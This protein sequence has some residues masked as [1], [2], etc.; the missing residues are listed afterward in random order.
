MLLEQNFSYD[1]CYPY[2]F[3]RSSKFLE[4]LPVIEEELVTGHFPIWFLKQKDP[5]FSASFN[6]IVIRDPIERVLS[7]YR[8]HL[9]CQENKKRKGDFN[10]KFL[11]KSPLEIE[12]N[13]ISKMLSSNPN[14]E[15]E[16]LFQ[17]CL[18]NL[19]FIDHIIFQ[20]DPDTF[21]SGIKTLFKRLNIQNASISIPKLNTTVHSD[22]SASML[23]KLKELNWV[24]LQLYDFIKKNHKENCS[25][26]RQCYAARDQLLQPK[27]SITYSFDLPVLGSGWAERRGVHNSMYGNG[28]ARRTR[29]EGSLSYRLIKG[30]SADMHFNLTRGQSYILEFKLKSYKKNLTPFLLVNNTHLK[31]KKTKNHSFAS[32]R[33]IIPKELI[34]NNLTKITFGSDVKEADINLQD[35]ILA[36]NLITIKKRSS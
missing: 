30:K 29:K 19:K 26:Y 3:G 16:E 13:V 14:L 31:I 25:R 11:K 17:S 21:N 36:L 9:K 10:P 35:P 27:D 1:E 5:S 18:K 28:A 20:D 23:E 12:P 32:Y 2:R 15:G 8:Y 7:Q 4:Q 33:A 6:F 34:N 24:D 22:V